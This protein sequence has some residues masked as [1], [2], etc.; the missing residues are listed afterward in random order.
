MSNIVEFVCTTAWFPGNNGTEGS[1]EP[2][3][4]QHIAIEAN[5]IYAKL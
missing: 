1:T 3:Y 2:S 5:F 4:S